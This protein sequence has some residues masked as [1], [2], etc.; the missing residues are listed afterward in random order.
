MYSKLAVFVHFS[1]ILKYD[2]PMLL[3]SSF[4]HPP[5]ILRLSI[6]KVKENDAWSIE[7]GMEVRRIDLSRNINAGVNSVA[8]CLCVD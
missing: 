6:I 1:A 2:S 8:H 4:V 5:F 3:R 7:G